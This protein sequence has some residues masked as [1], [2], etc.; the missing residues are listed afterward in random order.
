MEYKID[1][2]G[3]RISA[4]VYDP[5]EDEALLPGSKVSVVFPEE[6]FHVLVK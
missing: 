4:V 6:S 5:K 3:E 1:I 2:Q